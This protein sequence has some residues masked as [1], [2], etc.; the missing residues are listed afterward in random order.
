MSAVLRQRSE[1]LNEDLELRRS[2]RCALVEEARAAAW[3]RQM[4]AQRQ[5]KQHQGEEREQKEGRGDDLPVNILQVTK[6]EDAAIA[7]IEK[8]LAMLQR[9]RRTR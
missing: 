1:R 8:E 2:V 3:R 7:G 9:M 5:P 4:D 6:N